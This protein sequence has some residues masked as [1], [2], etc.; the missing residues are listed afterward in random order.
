MSKPESKAKAGVIIGRNKKS[1]K[2]LVLSIVPLAV[3]LVAA[4]IIKVQFYPSSQCQGRSSGPLYNKAAEAMNQPDN[5]ALN[6]VATQIKT[7][8]GYQDDPNCLLPV[9][10]NAINGGDSAAAEPLFNRLKEMQ[11]E[12]EEFAEPYHAAGYITMSEVERRFEILE[13]NKGLNS[14]STVLF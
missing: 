12:G 5:D 11:G 10:I 2:R 9:T 3:L 1:K 6:E 13:D 14:G 8:A 4:V 7:N